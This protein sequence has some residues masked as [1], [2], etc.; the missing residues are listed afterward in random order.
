MIS[1]TTQEAEAV[2]EAE[3]RKDIDAKPEWAINPQEAEN[4]KETKARSDINI[5]SEQ[6]VKIQ[7]Q[8][9]N[10]PEEGFFMNALKG[11]V[12]SAAEKRDLQHDDRNQEVVW[13]L[14]SILS[15]MYLRLKTHQMA[16]KVK[17]CIFSQPINRDHQRIPT[18]QAR[19]RSGY[20]SH[21]PYLGHQQHRLPHWQDGN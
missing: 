2:D 6:A 13:I 7:E 8:E 4:I 21:Q 1:N 5:K 19:S 17:E 9:F 3:M 11:T 18:I 12:A 16:H 14:P 20:R 15:R 10:E